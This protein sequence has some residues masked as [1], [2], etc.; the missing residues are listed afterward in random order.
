MIVSKFKYF[1]FL[2]LAI[3]ISTSLGCGGDEPNTTSAGTMT[4]PRWGHTSTLLND[5]RLLVVGGQERPSGAVGTAE[6]YDLVSGVW[7][8]AGSTIEPRGEGHSA[9]ILADGRVLVI[10]STESGLS[11]I[12]DPSGG[13][14]SS[15]GTMI[16][17]RTWASATLLEDGRVLVAGGLDATKTGRKEVESAE[18]F[19]PSTEEWTATGN[20]EQV[21]SGQSVVLLDG[22]PLLI[23]KF[24]A[25]I[26]DPA[27]GTWSSAGKP[28][29]ERSLGTTA[30]VMA[31]GKVIVTGGEFQRGGWTG[32]NS[33]PISSTEIYDPV[34]NTWTISGHMIEGRQFHS[35]VLLKNG[36]VMVIGGMQMDIYDPT[37]VEDMK[38]PVA[39]LMIE[40]RYRQYTATLLNDGRVIVVGGMNQTEAGN[41]GIATAEIY[42]PST[43]NAE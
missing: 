3:S 37:I 5:G 20:M 14:W 19:D 38:W 10:G 26:Y 25:E 31:D 9:T 7:S 35:A 36:K 13:N 39:A 42:D 8:S 15:A 12:Y 16:K 1:C 30:T 41:R 28:E 32:V 29:R 24:L 17:A 34:A 2:I 23:G 27:S 21:H 4:T 33:A 6:L 18:I 22:K 11:E 43:A 40:E